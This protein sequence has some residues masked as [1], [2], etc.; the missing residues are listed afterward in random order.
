MLKVKTPNYLARIKFPMKRITNWIY[1]Q[2]IHRSRLFQIEKRRGKS[3]SQRTELIL[4]HAELL[5][6]FAESLTFKKLHLHFPRDSEVIGYTFNA[7]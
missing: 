1:T 6:L 5:E 3:S 4:Y 2:R 7:P